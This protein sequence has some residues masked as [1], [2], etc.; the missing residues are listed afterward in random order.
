M[1]N[2]TRRAVGAAA[3]VGAVTAT[4][5]ATGVIVLDRTV[6]TIGRADT[7]GSLVVDP[8]GDEGTPPAVPLPEDPGEAPALTDTYTAAVRLLPEH[9][10]GDDPFHA[11]SDTTLAAGTY[12][13]STVTIDPGVVVT[14]EGA[15]LLRA[16]GDVL[17]EGSIRATAGGASITILCDGDFTARA[18]DGYPAPVL[19]AGA[20]P[21]TF[22][23]DAYGDVIVRGA[24]GN[25]CSFVASEGVLL[26]ARSA[27]STLDVL[28]AV[29]DAGSHGV[30]LRSEGDLVAS[31]FQLTRSGGG[32]H[33][34]AFGG[35]AELRA[36]D[37]DT[38]GLGIRLSA[39]GTFTFSGGTSIRTNNATVIAES[40]D[41][42]LAEGSVI[43]GTF[44]SLSAGEGIELLGGAA[45]RHLSSWA[46]LVITAYGADFLAGEDGSAA[47]VETV[48]T[49]GLQLRVAGGVSIG[50]EAAIRG[51]DG[52]IR[53]DAA[54][55]SVVAAGQVVSK[56]AAVEVRAAGDV[57]LTGGTGSEP[58]V[59]GTEVRIA[60]GAAA[61]LAGATAHDGPIDIVAGGDV[62]LREALSATAGLSAI[63]TDGNLLATDAALATEPAADVSGSIL[64]EAWS[65]DAGSIDLT[66]ASLATGDAAERSGDI[67]VRIRTRSPAQ[68]EAA[69]EEPTAQEPESP[70]A[71]APAAQEAPPAIDSPL[72][73]RR[74]RAKH[75]RRDTWTLAGDGTFDASS[76]PDS[77]G[78]TATLE[79]AG[80]SRELR[81]VGLRRGVATYLDDGATLRV[82]T[83]DTAGVLR[84]KMRTRVDIGEA[85]SR[86]GDGTLPIR[87]V[88]GED[89]SGASVVLR[90]GRVRSGE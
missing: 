4:A 62:D 80:S 84:F 2:M 5:L 9:R 26:S 33:I 34:A 85:L 43:Q 58:A 12:D 82:R 60:A 55:G 89:R 45:F 73:L 13:V 23:V 15:V 32:M 27:T 42:V 17:I 64:L 47:L 22:A 50:A 72:S 28:H 25:E 44:G 37:I 68:P 79:V 14:C 63:T 61:T 49:G 10:G 90:R 81:L 36:C 35:D 70:A 87:L 48:G 75:A 83:S 76:A 41:I 40:G 71:E 24:E 69:P 19:R 16:K 18:V 59:S 67:V 38:V 88:F 1:R 52:P 30:Y 77:L 74:L 31:S 46:P 53:I 39:A 65:G 56:F 57:S 7:R 6:L 51:T 11:T 54:S 66:R 3:L 86:G 8:A 29:A 21:G 20:F 78:P